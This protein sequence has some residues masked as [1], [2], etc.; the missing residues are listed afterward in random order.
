MSFSSQYDAKAHVN[1]DVVHWHVFFKPA[2]VPCLESEGHYVLDNMAIAYA[3][4]R[5]K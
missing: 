1:F 4:T 3:Y 5:T 2:Y